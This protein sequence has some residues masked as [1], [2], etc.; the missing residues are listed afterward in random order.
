MKANC[1]WEERDNRL[2]SCQGFVSISL[3][4]LSL[5][6]SFYQSAS[7]HKHGTSPPNNFPTDCMCACAYVRT[8]VCVCWICVLCVEIRKRAFAL[9]LSCDW[10]AQIR[11][12]DL[13]LINNS[14]ITL[15]C[16]INQHS[17]T[18]TCPE[19]LVWNKW[20]CACVP[21]LVYQGNESVTLY[22]TLICCNIC[23]NI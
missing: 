9:R 23:N 22:I 6:L 17:G 1:I 12:T 3:C 10:Q 20:M 18:L 2:S 5:S 21:V 15:G 13:T 14:V 7:P 8:C 19:A 16:S 11:I 4:F